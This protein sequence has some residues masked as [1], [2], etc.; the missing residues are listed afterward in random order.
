M[1]RS[2]MEKNIREYLYSNTSSGEVR[3]FG[4]DWDG[5]VGHNGWFAFSEDGNSCW[6]FHNYIGNGNFETC[7]PALEDDWNYIGPWNSEGFTDCDFR[8]CCMT[9]YNLIGTVFTRCKFNDD[10]IDQYRTYNHTTFTECE[11]YTPE[12]S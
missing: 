10:T 2:I 3:I 7:R 8:G 5:S 11:W 4:F 12:T 6:F 1:P 9:H